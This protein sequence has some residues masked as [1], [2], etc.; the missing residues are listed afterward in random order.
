[1]TVL[2]PVCPVP[3]VL[4][5]RCRAR[6]SAVTPQSSRGMTREQWSHNVIPGQLP[7]CPLTYLNNNVQLVCDLHENLNWCVSPDTWLPTP[8]S[9][10]AACFD[11]APSYHMQSPWCDNLRGKEAN[12]RGTGLEVG[13]NCQ[14][15]S[16]PA[17]AGAPAWR[18]SKDILIYFGFYR[19]RIIPWIK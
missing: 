16:S 5:R 1:M 18:C 19:F 2:F 17:G 7:A 8:R 11:G 3:S 14:L 12:A 15:C 6:V 10:K 9:S 4:P 13:G